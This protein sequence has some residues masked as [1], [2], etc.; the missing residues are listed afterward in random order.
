MLDEHQ[1]FSID[2]LLTEGSFFYDCDLNENTY[3]EQI[4]NMIELDKDVD[5]KIIVQLLKCREELMSTAI[6]HGISLPHP[7]IPL[8]VGSNK[9]ILNVF[10]PRKSLNLT[11]IDGKPVHT[12]ILLI[13]Q[14]ITQHLSLLAE[15]SYLLSKEAF[16]FA[17]ENRLKSSEIIDIQQHI[18]DTRSL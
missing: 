15:L 16:H 18:S 11:S 3:I 1:I 17:L 14:T 13:S 7:R 8:V 5:R 12:I 2:S 6:G 10:F 4:V 9:P